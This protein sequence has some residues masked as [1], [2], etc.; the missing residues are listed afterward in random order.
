MPG[1]PNA[2]K[3]IDVLELSSKSGSIPGAH[4]DRVLVF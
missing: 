1:L 4:D 3:I 2:L